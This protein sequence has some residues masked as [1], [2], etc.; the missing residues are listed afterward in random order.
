MLGNVRDVWGIVTHEVIEDR[1][2]V[3]HE[4]RDRV[5]S[6][7]HEVRTYRWSVKHKVRDARGNLTK[8]KTRG[9]VLHMK[10]KTP[11]GGVT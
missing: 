2:S 10:L 5:R 7:T 3:M 1:V 6:V 9:E 11:G 4:V 8:S